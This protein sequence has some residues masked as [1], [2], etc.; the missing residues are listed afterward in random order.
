MA[1]I[2]FLKEIASI[3]LRPGEYNLSETCV[4]FPNKRA[5]LY[6]SKYIGELTDKPV[7][8]PVYTTINE[9]MEKLSGYIYADK[10]TLLFELFEIYRQATKSDENFENFYTYADPLLADFDEID[11][12]LADARDLFSN[13]AGLKA[14]EGRFSYLSGEQVAAIRQFWNT[15]DPDRSSEGQKT[16]ISLWNVMQ[17]MYVQLRHNLSSRG[18]AY[19]GMAYRKV[20]EDI[21]GD[22]KMEGLDA[23]RYLFVGFNALNKCEERLFRYLK[24]NGKAEFYWDYDSWYAQNE[25]H[26][27]GL[28]IRKNLHDFP[29]T[30][31][32]NHENLVS[33]KKNIYFFPVPSNTGQ[34]EALPLVFEK[35]GIQLTSEARHTA[36]VLADENLLIPV[37]YAIPESVT[38]LNITMGYPILGSVVFNLA[39]SLYELGKNKRAEP[40]GVF[41]YY[42]KDVLS[43]L[44]NPLLKSVYGGQIQRVRQLIIQNNLVYLSGKDILE[45]KNE[46]F[47]FYSGKEKVNACEYLAGVF[48][49]MI[50]KL[51]APE[52]ETKT[53]PVQ[54]EILFQVYT[55]LTR[56]K[57]ILVNYTFEP[58]YETLFRLIRRMLKTLHIPF[59]GE[60]LSGLQVLGILE[61]RTLDFDNVIILSMNEGILPRSSANPSFIPQNL[62]F[63]FGLPTPDHQDSIYAYYF[64]RL[65]QRA[66]N[67]VLIYDSSTG[68]LRTGERSRF[69]HQLFYELPSGV[70]E[71]NPSY[72]VTLIRPAP[73]IIEK[74]GDVADALLLYTG[75]GRK[76]LSPSALNEFLNC[77][78]RFYFHH[79]AGLPQP[80]EVTEDIDARIFGNLLHKAMQILYGRFGSSL[81][82]KE[83]LEDILK[84][85]DMINDAL[86]RSFREVLFGNGEGSSSRNI[87][88]FNLIVR[89]IIRSYIHNIVKVD[90]GGGAF[91]ITDLEKRVDTT[92]PVAIAENILSVK[93]G[94]TIDRVDLFEGRYRILDYKTGMIKN[95]FGTVSGLFDGSEKMRNDAVFQVLLYAMIYQRLIPDG[96]IVPALCFVR[97]S[98]SENFSYS[99]Q[100]GEKKKKLEDYS[101]VKKEFEEL[102]HFHLARLFN[103]DEPFTHTENVKICQNCPYAVI[104][105]KEGK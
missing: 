74:K 17:E 44:G 91:S 76:I 71:I 58:G 26:E 31:P 22:H 52:N 51:A 36:L 10:L 79:I 75:T 29:Q 50:R 59:N 90:A 103:P 12:Y 21:A 7:W 15:F 32:I 87:E 98:H 3:L 48:E 6:L 78:L 18:L 9:L 25:I 8:A 86:E 35:L 47:L 34:A 14:L 56:L 46:D 39:D 64:Y 57:D 19:E 88:G 89:Q 80:E 41:T 62:R 5:R 105:R 20:A 60:P 81:I 104:C 42:F 92:I 61:T 100:Y 24:N 94:G 38:N 66:S 4:V 101:E 77:S 67:V 13:L 55:F 99:I 33:E 1:S 28:F 85:D 27:A 45:D 93:L 84:K 40:G 83:Q 97:G 30:R 43:I 95:S 63:G 49:F 70:E 54:M 11:K 2:P 68:G 73:I 23:G 37:L 69:M 72:P 102:I 82:T 96:I 65:I 16:F 53:D